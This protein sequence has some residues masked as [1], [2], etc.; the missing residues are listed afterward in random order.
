MQNEQHWDERARNLLKAEL[1]RRGISYEDLRVALEN[2]GIHKTVA[3]INTTI[4]RG[5][6]SFI[7]FLQV[8][9]AIRLEQIRLN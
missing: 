9:E 2:I 8:A 5:R 1:T 3:N 4:N 7:F 6:F